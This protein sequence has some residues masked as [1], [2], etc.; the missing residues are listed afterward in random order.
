MKKRWKNGEKT[1]KNDEKCWTAKHAMG[2]FFGKIFQRQN[3]QRGEIQGQIQIQI[4]RKLKRKRKQKRKR[5][6]LCEGHEAPRVGCFPRFVS[7]FVSIY[8]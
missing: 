4:K 7:V 1:M 8:V 2:G 5:G 3:T 6:N